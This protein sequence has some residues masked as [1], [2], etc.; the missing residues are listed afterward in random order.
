MVRTT[1]RS[2]STGARALDWRTKMAIPSIPTGPVIFD[3]EATG[4]RVYNMTQDNARDGY[5][6]LGS[7]NNVH[8]SSSSADRFIN[9]Q[10][11]SDT[12][13]LFG[14]GNDF[15]HSGS[16]DDNVFGGAGNDQLYGGSGNDWLD[17]FDGDDKLYG[18]SGTDTLSGG[19][20]TDMLYGGSG[21]D[22]LWGGDGVDILDGGSGNDTLFGDGDGGSGKD[23]LIGGRGNDTLEGGGGADSLSGG[24]DADTFVFRHQN[25][26]GLGHTDVIT[27]FS[28]AAGDRID[29]SLIDA[30]VGGTANDAFSFRAG[31]STEVGTLWLGAVVDGQQSVFMN[32]DGGA[33]DLQIIVKLADAVGLVQS[34]FLL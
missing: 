21:A 8:Q 11:G 1:I 17:G 7:G 19:I 15:I 2:I 28:H 18:G 5:V 26:L 14:T 12:I 25:D 31:P 32:R 3:T 29:V 33:A 6:N 24:A 13:T 10:G 22:E 30:R 23:Y 20:G 9:S 16:G 4:E 27:D 34:D